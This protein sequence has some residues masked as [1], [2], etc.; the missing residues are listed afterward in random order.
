MQSGRLCDVAC[1]LDAYWRAIY[2]VL[3]VAGLSRDQIIQ[4]P[5]YQEAYREMVQHKQDCPVCQAA[6]A[7]LWRWGWEVIRKGGGVW[8]DEAESETAKAS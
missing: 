4:S 7:E 8:R 2:H 1:G 5:A 6:R 3:A